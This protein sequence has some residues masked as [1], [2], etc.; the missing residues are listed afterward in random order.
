MNSWKVCQAEDTASAKVLRPK[1]QKGARSRGGG[2]S[3]DGVGGALSPALLEDRK[4]GQPQGLPSP[5]SRLVSP[6]L[7]HLLPAGSSPRA[8]QDCGALGARSR[9]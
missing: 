3:G 7:V 9:V 2:G 1:T 8:G 6:W 5:L 4:E